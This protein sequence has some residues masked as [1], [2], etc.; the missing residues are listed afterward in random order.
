M[1]HRPDEPPLLLLLLVVLRHTTH[2]TR[3]AMSGCRA[4][5]PFNYKAW[6]TGHSQPHLLL[7]LL[8]L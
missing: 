4:A 1:G 7:L 2:V 8:L 6:A 5:S 3:P